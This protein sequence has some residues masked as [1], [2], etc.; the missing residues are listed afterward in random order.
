MDFLNLGLGAIIS[1]VCESLK[2]AFSNWKKP[3]VSNVHFGFVLPRRTVINRHLDY[4]YAASLEHDEAFAIVNGKNDWAVDWV[5]SAELAFDV[6]NKTSSR[7]IS[8]KGFRLDTKELPYA[9]ES[10]Y[11]EIPQGNSGSSDMLRFAT[12]LE[13]RR[14][15]G[16]LSFQKYCIE[17]DQLHLLED[18]D[19]FSFGAITLK[20]GDIK[21]INLSIVCNKVAREIKRA[22]MIYSANERQHEVEI[23]LLLPIRIFPLSSISEDQRYTYTYRGEPPILR[24]EK[25]LAYENDICMPGRWDDYPAS[26]SC[27][28]QD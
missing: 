26:T 25:D 11:L 19:Y 23:P 24:L 14:E 18:P 2:Q 20:P 5:N 10:S 15:D 16:R 22:Y 8:I 17:D 13:M 12:S 7:S 1:T 28:T 21:Y 9:P 6:T 27:E 4:G 3:Q